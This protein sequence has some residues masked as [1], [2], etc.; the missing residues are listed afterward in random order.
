MNALATSTP[1]VSTVYVISESSAFTLTVEL[2]EA[3]RAMISIQFE[4]NL[5]TGKSKSIPVK[6]LTHNLLRLFIGISPARSN[7]D[8]EGTA[9]THISRLKE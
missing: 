1:I 2:S 7:T 4:I 5:A 8:R 9:R 6:G 3:I